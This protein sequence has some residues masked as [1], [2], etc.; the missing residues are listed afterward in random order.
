[1]HR[2]PNLRNNVPH[3]GRWTP[4]TIAHLFD[5]P[6][7]SDD[8]FVSK[9]FAGYGEV[10]N[11][12][13]QKYLS[14]DAVYTGTRLVS[15][16]MKHTPP[17]IV[18][19]NGILCRTWYKGQPVVCNICNVQ[20]HKSNSCPN[21]DKCRLCG[22]SGHFARSCP[23]PWSRS[24]SSGAQ[25]ASSAQPPADEAQPAP[26]VSPGLNASDA[27][28]APIDSQASDAPVPVS[29]QVQIDG[30][31]AEAESP[32]R[33]V[34]VVHGAVEVSS[35]APAP[36][37][38]QA[39]AS[40]EASV[41]GSA[42]DTPLVRASVIQVADP[43]MEEVSESPLIEE[44][45]SAAS[46]SPPIVAVEEEIFQDASEYSEEEQSDASQSILKWASKPDSSDRL[47]VSKSPV[48]STPPEAAA[49]S[50]ADCPIES[51]HPGQSAAAENLGVS[52][53]SEPDF[54]IP[55]SVQSALDA[56]NEES[57]ECLSQSLK[58]KAPEGNDVEGA[59][60][61]PES[62]PSRRSRNKPYKQKKFHWPGTHSGLPAVPTSHWR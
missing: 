9:V 50:N 30:S 31:P 39:P 38:P 56:D 14:D 20:G 17:R 49:Q 43:P 41:A 46:D 60:A 36:D 15:F 35:D 11:I 48:A 40:P 53:P 34:T 59:S 5:Y 33:V 62:V 55:D 29:L 1:M 13:K 45:S 27:P 44:F 25:Q 19:V 16:I 10:K 3:P 8:S 2:H 51:V 42:P 23:N 22:A 52:A 6:F 28:Q 58:R 26:Q 57:M 7:E 61:S 12:R 32:T 37:T 4:V 24:A 47:E 18:T 21:K 54:S